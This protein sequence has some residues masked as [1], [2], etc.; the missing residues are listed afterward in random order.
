M[1]GVKG[2]KAALPSPL[3]PLRRLRQVL[4]SVDGCIRGAT[5]RLGAGT[6]RPTWSA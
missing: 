1:S 5:C 4:A 6:H 2:N 3:R